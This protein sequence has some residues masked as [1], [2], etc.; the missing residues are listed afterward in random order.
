LC[1]ACAWRSSHAF[2]EAF[3]SRVRN[4]GPEQHWFGLLEEAQTTI[5]AWR[6]D[7]ITERPHG[8]LGHGIP[9]EF[10]RAWQAPAQDLAHEMGADQSV[11]F[12]WR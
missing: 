4:E 6:V 3:N 8:A 1:A 11:Y 9:V 5:G 7:D 12:Y 2:I 10:S